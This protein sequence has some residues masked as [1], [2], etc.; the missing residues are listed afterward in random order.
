MKSVSSI[1]GNIMVMHGKDVE[2]GNL[3]PRKYSFWRE[4]FATL[5]EIHHLDGY[6]GLFLTTNSK[7]L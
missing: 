6:F 3:I 7:N 4:I 5:R 1:M 2:F